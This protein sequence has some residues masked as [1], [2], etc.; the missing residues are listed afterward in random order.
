MMKTRKGHNVYPITVA[1]KFP[2]VLC[3]VLSEYGS[4]Q[5]RYKPD[6]RHGA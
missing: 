5:Y 6:N 1:Q 2:F 4:T 3:K